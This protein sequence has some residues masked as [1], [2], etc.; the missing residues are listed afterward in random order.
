MANGVTNTFTNGTVANANEVNQNFTEVIS[1]IGI[2]QPWLKTFVAVSSG[3]ATT[4][5]TDKLVDSGATF[6]TDGASFDMI[7][8]N[9]TDDVFGVVS[10]VDSETSISLAADTKSGSAVTDV[11]PDGNE[12]YFVYA[13]PKLPDGW[14]EVNGQTV[15]DAD[16]P[17]N[18]QALPDLNGESGTNRFLRGSTTSGTE[19]GSETHNHQWANT[20]SSNGVA[21]EGTGFDK[22]DKSWD[23]SGNS[24][25]LDA[26][27][28]YLKGEYWT[29]K[30]STL[31][32]YYEVVWI[33]RIK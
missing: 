23:S 3:T 31:P 27:H 9:S 22:F 32:S 4:D 14:L 6:S 33:M 13:T 7:V 11:F 30:V 29:T 2:I 26:D 28:S 5:T 24:K 15:S 17:Y 18:G 1:P 16:S 19:D 12:D 10:A 8:Y 25:D 20:G 21:T